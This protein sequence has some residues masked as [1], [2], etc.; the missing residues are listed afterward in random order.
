MGLFGNESTEHGIIAIPP[1]LG[2]LQECAST[3]PVNSYNGPRR[4]IPIMEVHTTLLLQEFWN[5]YLTPM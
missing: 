4:T 2:G 3:P 5:M 1:P